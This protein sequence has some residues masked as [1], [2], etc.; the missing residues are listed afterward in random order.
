MSID[1]GHT[2]KNGVTL[3]DG[4]IEL[5]HEPDVH[6]QLRIAEQNFHQHIVVRLQ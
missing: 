6:V 5:V 1:A 3:S 4:G 2:C